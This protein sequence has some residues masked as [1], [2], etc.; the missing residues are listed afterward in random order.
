MPAK[1]PDRGVAAMMKNVV[2]GCVIAVLICMFL[3]A[4][5]QRHEECWHGRILGTI[6]PCGSVSP[7]I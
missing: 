3:L 5:A 2:V 4:Y 6:R 7:K 1:V